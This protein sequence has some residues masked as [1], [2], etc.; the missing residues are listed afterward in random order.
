MYKCDQFFSLDDT[1]KASHVHLA[2]TLLDGLELQWHLNYMRKK[3]DIYPTWAQYVRDISIRFGDAYEDRLSNLIQVKHSRKIQDYIV[4]F[5]VSQHSFSIFLA[6]LEHSTK[7][8]VRLFNPT[9]IAQALNLACWFEA[10]KHIKPSK[11]TFYAYKSTKFYTR[12]LP[13]SSN[14]TQATLQTQ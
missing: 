4:E 5:E 8:Y 1:P 11:P 14:T 12:F 9:S 2:S 7:M 3:F 6:G 10:S 13:S